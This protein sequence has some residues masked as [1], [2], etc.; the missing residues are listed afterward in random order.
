[1]ASK[2]VLLIGGL[3]GALPTLINL[4]QVDA[5]TMFEGFDL[6]TLAG[7]GIRT[8]LLIGLGMLFVWINSETNLKKAL[9]LGIMAPAIIVGYINSANLNEVKSELSG[10]A[11]E[12]I[13][14]SALS[15][16]SDA[17]LAQ[18]NTDIHAPSFS[19]I[20]SAYADNDTRT[21]TSKR[22]K[23]SHKAP[24]KLA[25]LWYGMSGKSAESWFVIVNTYKTETEAK[26]FVA[27]LKTQGYAALVRPTAGKDNEY[28]VMIGS[29]L[30]LL[31]AKRLKSQAIKDGLSKDIHLWKL[32]S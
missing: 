17:S 25:R 11:A 23:G 26:T 31:N 28:R 27:E 3:G 6:V 16:E 30:T 18:I 8:L 21:T 4:V 2:K 19:F 14:T 10:L 32:K 20:A 15:P 9:Q 24:G 22:L 29:W 5:A 1:M 13:V 7:Y 12:E